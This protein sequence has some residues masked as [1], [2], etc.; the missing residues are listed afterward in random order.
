MKVPFVDLKPMHS[1]IQNDLEEAFANVL[2]RSNYIL[3]E[4][5]EKFEKEFADYI[6]VKHCIGVANGLDALTLILKAM[7]LRFLMQQLQEIRPCWFLRI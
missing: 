3:G 1:E 2:D 4:E 5:C 7:G 6:G